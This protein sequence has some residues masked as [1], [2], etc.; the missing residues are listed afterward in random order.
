MTVTVDDLAQH[1]GFATT[2]ADTDV[3]DRVLSTAEAMLLP[4][5]LPGLEPSPDQAA[6]LDLAT[7]TVAQDLWRRKDSS[8]GSFLWGDGS[9]SGGV[10]PRDQIHSVWPI[11]CAAGLVAPTVFA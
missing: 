4:Y 1:L 10:L 2:P 8:G 11:L 9:D 6:A 5:L 7:L 3:L